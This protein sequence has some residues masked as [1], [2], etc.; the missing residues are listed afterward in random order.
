MKDCMRRF[1]KVLVVELED[2]DTHIEE[3]V[4]VQNERYA[5]RLESE[6]VCLENVATLRNEACGLH[7]FVRIVNTI[8]LDQFQD[9][10]QLIDH[11]RR[12]FRAELKRCG[13]APAAYVFAERKMARVEH[14]VKESEHWCRIQARA[15][16]EQ[17]ALEQVAL[18]V[19]VAEQTG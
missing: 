3:L 2:L 7:H 12:T 13:L 16:L 4:Q 10:D 17:A 18:E 14:Y 1:L 5:A 15:A 11:L 8:D 9:L 6:Y 19:I